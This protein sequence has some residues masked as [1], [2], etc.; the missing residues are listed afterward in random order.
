MDARI[1]SSLAAL[2]LFSVLVV[3]AVAAPVPFV[4]YRPGPTF[5]VLGASAGEEIVTVAGHRAYRD[6]GELRFTTVSVTS[7]EQRLNVFDLLAA[8]ASSTDAVFPREVVYGEDETAEE[9]ERQSSIQMVTSQDAAIA[10][11]MRAAGDTVP[12]ATEVLDVAAGSGADGALKVGDELVAVGDVEIG[13]AADVVRAVQRLEPGDEVQVRVRRDG[14]L[15]TL[16][17]TVQA[18]PDE[19]G[20]AQLGV[21]VGPGYQFPYEVDV[22]VADNVGGPSAGLM[23]ALAV[24]DTLTPGSLTDGKVVSG[25][26]TI[27]DDGSVGP[28][29]GIAQKILGADA[30]DAS[31]FFVPADNCAAA[32]A[33]PTPDGMRLVRADDFDQALAALQTWAEDPD[34]DLP[35]C[36]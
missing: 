1:R 17:V 29:G 15:L 19:P 27:A 23:F 22:A 9:A 7:P 28:I 3:A 6:D 24:Y 16:P 2:G 4:V 25:T 20:R 36:P 33:A 21:V 13:A 12:E 31:L 18:P 34:A 10:N 11:A 30:A 35:R 14:E 8:W 26:G 32:T 5:D